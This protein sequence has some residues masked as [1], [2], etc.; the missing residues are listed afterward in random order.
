MAASGERPTGTVTFLFSDIEGST[1]LLQ[2]LGA[3]YGQALAEHQRLLRE[4][5][6]AHG[7]HEIDTQGDS[8]FVAFRR[9][10]NAVAAAIDGQRALAAFEWPDGAELRVR[11]GIHTGEPTEN[12]ERYVGL[13]V[14]R[15]ARIGAAAVGGQV[16]T[17]ETTRALLRDDPLPDVTLRDLGAVRLKDISEPER[18][19]EVNAPG[20]AAVGLRTGTHSRRRLMAGAAIVA[21]AVAAA[22]GILLSRGASAAH[23]VEPNQV[24]VIDTKK[25]TISGAIGVGSAPN[26]VVA[27]DGAVWVANTDDNSVTKIDRSGQNV[28]QTIR[29]G[30]SPAGIAV[31]PDAVWVA[32]SADGTVSRIDP[33]FNASVGEIDVGNGPTSVAYGAG[34]IWVAN[35]ADGTISEIDP[36]RGKVGKVE[37]TFPGAVGVTALTIAFGHVWAAAPA[38][39][40]V[41]ELDPSSGNL[42]SIQVGNDPHAITAG[43][44]AIWVANRQD[45]TVWRIEPDSHSTTAT[46]T[47]FAAPDAIIDTD[48]AVWV[49]N[50]DAGTL[51]KIDPQTNTLVGTVSVANPPQSLATEGSNLYVSVRSSGAANRG[52]TL[53]VDAGPGSPDF[54]DPAYAY[55]PVSW[56]AL[57]LTNDGLVGFRRVGGAEGTQLV[58]D[59]ATAIPAP[60]PDGLTYTFTLRSGIR[61]SNGR[62]VQPRDIKLTLERSLSASHPIPPTRSYFATTIVGANRCTPGK[63]CRLSGIETGDRT[64]TF[65]L[66][67]PDPDFPTKLAMPPA[68][69][70]PPGTPKRA[71]HVVPA[72]G[73]YMI[74]AYSKKERTLKLARNPKFVEWSKDAQPAGFPS[75]IDFTWAADDATPNQTY[76]RLTTS[77]EQHRI[78]VALFPGSPPVP[79]QTLD[80]LTTRYPTQVRLILSPGTWYFFLNTRVPPFDDTRVRQAVA[81]A[82]D[83]GALRHLLTSEY[84]PTC[85]ILPPGYAGYQ[86]GCPYVGSPAKRLAQ[87]KALVKASGKDGMRVVVWTPEPD[88]RN[89]QFFVQLLNRLGFHASLHTVAAGHIFDYFT[90]IL[91]PHKRIQTGYVGWAADY[92]SS[93]AFFEQQLSCKGFTENVQTNSNVSEFCD[94]RI[95]A[96]INHAS[97]V[98]ALDPPRATLLWQKV[99]QDFLAAAP[100]IPAYNGRAIVFLSKRV[101]NFQYHPQWGTLLDQLW[102]R[103][104]GSG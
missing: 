25:G 7:G 70:V 28:Q 40:K 42:D 66:T 88:A 1:R 10:K 96:E 45:N 89:G 64:I 41:I 30:G 65:H 46:I 26:G 8:F 53:R 5:F 13:G 74:V 32:N 48:D 37:H 29:V 51:S 9:A 20:L 61:Y 62:L 100:M 99:G 54:F 80:R 95:D 67:A 87:G 4:A 35:A 78:D 73:P 104:S 68:Y 23:T 92:P 3:L 39:G 15:A 63:P 18:L 75:S 50:G 97:Q 79:K 44:G 36:A 77:V 2:R 38:S 69:A 12:E 76:A 57:A 55:T 34:K 84:T 59:L 82:F 11:M 27:G 91:D 93:L 103:N 43:F 81:T 56:Y 98:Q 60:S 31:S 102:V 90:S 21:I 49:A 19:F 52:G 85:N 14:H 86:R 94:H 17:S 83:R 71:Q 47:G 16:L 58:P 33:N 6:E 101:G 22:L 24:G 72:T